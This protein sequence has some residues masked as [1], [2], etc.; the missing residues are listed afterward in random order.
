MLVV[1]LLKTSLRL[2]SHIVTMAV[3]RTPARKAIR[4]KMTSSV[5]VKEAEQAVKSAVS[6]G[7][8]AAEFVIFPR[9]GS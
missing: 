2:S 9:P 7:D 6:T 1:K 4:T 5:V 8:G 3:T